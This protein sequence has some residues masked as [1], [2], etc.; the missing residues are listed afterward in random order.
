MPVSLQ[1][2]Y[3]QPTV[4]AVKEFQRLHNLRIT[5][6]VDSDTWEALGDEP[7]DPVAGSPPPGNIVILVDTDYLT[8]TV[9][10]DG[11]PFKSFPV[12]IG[13]PATPTPVGSWTV[14]DKGKWGGGLVPAGLA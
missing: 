6:K 14:V 9:L 5:G 8:L 2:V 3:D 1:G 12:A 11:K 7:G 10:V 13:K 4:A